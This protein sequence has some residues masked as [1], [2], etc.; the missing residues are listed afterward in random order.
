LF[1]SHVRYGKFSRQSCPKIAKT[2][3]PNPKGTATV[4]VIFLLEERFY[5][6]QIL[7]GQ[8]EFASFLYSIVS[9]V[10]ILCL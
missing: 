6:S 10:C 5:R 8:Y 1:T 4:I 9:I 7:R 3:N 2:T